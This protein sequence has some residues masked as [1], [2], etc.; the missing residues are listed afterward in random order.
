MTWLSRLAPLYSRVSG[1][2]VRLRHASSATDD[3]ESR[4]GQPPLDTVGDARRPPGGAGEKAPLF[5]VLSP[6]GPKG[7]RWTGPCGDWKGLPPDGTLRRR[8]GVL[9]P[10]LYMLCDLE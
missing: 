8:P 6:E 5:D 10:L 2:Q 7:P 1:C 3:T 9:E 4:L